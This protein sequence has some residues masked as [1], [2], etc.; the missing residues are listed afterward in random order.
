MGEMGDPLS[1][2]LM[3]FCSENYGTAVSE[4][5]QATLEDHDSCRAFVYL[6]AAYTEV[7][8]YNAAIGAFRRAADLRPDDPRMH[9]NL[10]QAY[11]AADVPDQA[12]YEYSLALQYDPEYERAHRANS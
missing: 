2:G 10:G 1:R 6:G 8:R 9:Y 5:E 12:L 4:L 7:G 3:A 11:E